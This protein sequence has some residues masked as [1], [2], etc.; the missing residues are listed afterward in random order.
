M[1][2]TFLALTAV[3]LGALILTAGCR[4][5]K[6]EGEYRLAEEQ[7][8]PERTHAQGPHGG[9]TFDLGHNHNFRFEL[10]FD[11]K[12]PRTL[13]IYLLEHDTDDPIYSDQKELTIQ[14]IKADGKELSLTLQA[15]PQEKDKEGMTSRFQATGEQIPTAIEDDHE[16]AGGRFSVTVG[17]TSY[18]G[19]IEGHGHGEHHDHDKDH[20]D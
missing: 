16:L 8:E 15:A 6:D 18:M 20:K 13:T 5:S 11:E 2:H 1:R 3:A 10:I 7:G 9:E 14:G 12:E 17:G 4:K 19:T